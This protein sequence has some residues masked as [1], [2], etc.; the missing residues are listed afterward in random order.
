MSNFQ[1]FITYINGEKPK[2][3]WNHTPPYALKTGSTLLVE[4]C[5][6]TETKKFKI[7]QAVLYVVMDKTFAFVL[8]KHVKRLPDPL[9]EN[10]IFSFINLLHGEPGE[11]VSITA[12]CCLWTFFSN[13]L[14]KPL[15]WKL[16]ACPMLNT[17]SCWSK[18]RDHWFTSGSV[19]EKYGSMFALSTKWL[20]IG[21]Y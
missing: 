20:H 15:N 21:P 18:W 10:G 2:M 7:V 17:T 13:H 14:R 19:V 1:K 3:R 6:S 8:K 5:T 4:M 12:V 16:H 9:A 11:I